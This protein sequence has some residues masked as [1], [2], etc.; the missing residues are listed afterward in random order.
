MKKN[1]V[2]FILFLFGLTF[3]CLSFFQIEPDYLWHVKAGEYMLQHGVL[4]HD[5]FSWSV[6]GN[7]WMSHEWLFE[8]IIA[9]LKKIFSHYHLLI[10][11]FSTTCFLLFTIY[12]GNRKKIFQNYLFSILW[13]SM[14]LLL[15][16]MMQ[17]RPHLLGYCLFALTIYFLYEF[18]Q[19]ENSKKIYFL[20]LIS[21]LWANVHGGSSNLVYLLPLFF[22]VFGSFSFQSSKIST[23]KITKKQRRV[24]FIIIILCILGVCLNIHGVKMLLYPYQNMMD[25]VMIQNISEWRSTSLNDPIHYLFFFFLLFSLAVLLFSKKKINF[26]DLMLFLLATYLGIK[27]IRFWFYSYLILSFVIFSYPSRRKMDK[28]TNGLLLLLSCFFLCLFLV[29]GGNILHPKYQYLLQSKDIQAIQKENPKRLY[30]LYNF[31]GDLVYHGIPVFVDGRAD[32]YG[33][34][35]Y[36]DYLSISKLQEDYVALIE[37]YDFDYF[38]VDDDYPISTYLRYEDDYELVYHRKDVYLYK[39]KTS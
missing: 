5:V 35:N 21:I 30:N 26:V 29:R 20:P 36:E 1:N 2:I 6:F 32:L 38:L 22:L 8:V 23:K 28:G 27:S 13:F 9:G 25:T 16:F 24:Y 12:F 7:Y 17:G 10:Y 11:C 37:K 18:Y 3:L 4:K 39:K 14:A 31:G 34:Y 15:C 19:D 33:K